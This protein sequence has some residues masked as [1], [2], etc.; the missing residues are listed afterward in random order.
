MP[1]QPIKIISAALHASI[2]MYIGVAFFMA[3]N[4]ALD[5]TT[6]WVIR[7][8][9]QT[10]LYVLTGVAV[11]AGLYSLLLPRFAKDPRSQTAASGAV[12]PLFFDFSESITPRILN[13]TIVRMALAEAVAIQ[14]LVLSLNNRS[15]MVIVPYAIAGLVLQI[16]VGAFG[17]V[18]RG[19]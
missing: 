4:S 13:L 16:L 17:S 10:L 15:A 7:P 8:E 5:W 1:S 2:L 9:N 19:K 11:V 18:L 14:G 12:E 6:A 3:K